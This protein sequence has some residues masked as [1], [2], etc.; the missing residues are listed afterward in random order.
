MK[1]FTKLF[2]SCAAIAAVTAAVATSAMAAEVSLTGDVLGTYNT[3]TG[4]LELTAPDVDQGTEA[5]L[6]VFGADVTDVTQDDVVGI[7]QATN[8][9]FANTGLKDAPQVPETGSNKYTVKLGYYADG[10]FTVK[11]GVLLLGEEDGVEIIVGDANVDGH[12]RT[13]DANAILWYTVDTESAN[14]AKVGKV[15]NVS[16]GTTAKVGDANLDG[17]IRTNDA[18]AILWYTV[19]PESA[20]AANVG[21]VLIGTV[22]E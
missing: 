19:D 18:N 15:I 11:S 4:K 5:T 6:L 22:T 17:N 12:I 13:N 2:L 21:Q 20:N 7:D 1:K 3:E 16:D 8:A 9:E 10:V 14:A